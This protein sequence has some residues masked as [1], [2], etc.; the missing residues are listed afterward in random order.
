M[1]KLQPIFP[2]TFKAEKE[3]REMMKIRITSKTHE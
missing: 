3:Y 1:K 2:N